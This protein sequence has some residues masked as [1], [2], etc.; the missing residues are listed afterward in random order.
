MSVSKRTYVRFP[1]AYR[2][3]HLLLIASFSTLAFTGL[4]QKFP[5]FL[6]SQ[7]FIGLLGGIEV[8]RIIHRVAA[9]VMALE[10]VYHLGVVGYRLFVTRYRLTM[11]PDLGDLRAALQSLLYNLGLSDD[12]PLEGRYTFAEKAEYWALVWGTIVMGI[13]G[14]MMW[15]PIASAKILPGEFIP[16]AKAAHGSEAVLAALAILVWHF[17]HVHLKAFNKS[18][19]SGNLTEREMAH[20]HPLELAEIKAGTAAHPADPGVVRRRRI[21]LPVFLV[22][23]VLM[24]IGVLR[25][26][27]FEE[28]AIATMPP[29]EDVQVFVPLTPTPFPTPLPTPTPAEEIKLVWSGG[30]GD[31]ILQRCGVC[32]GSGALMGGLDVTSL[33]ALLAGGDSGAG[34][35]PGDPDASLL[36]LRQA[37]GDHPALLGGAELALLRRWIE[38]GAPAD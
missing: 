13:T 17:Y 16:A 19:F 1:L 4:A 9:I 18:M 8:V 2:I 6:A 7:R 38:A 22:L 25:F 33:E 36:I 32:H 14:F 28:T 26:A 23:A 27:T 21:Y 20:E 31:L 30:V 10:T 37:T 15:N 3:E 29:I 34:V 12:R 24:V 5:L 11:M 35:V